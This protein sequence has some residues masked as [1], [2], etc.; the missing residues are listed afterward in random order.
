MKSHA[1]DSLLRCNEALYDL[2]LLQI[3]A[4]DH[5]VPASGEKHIMFRP[6]N[7]AV[8]RITKLK[9]RL[10]LLCKWVPL[11]HRAIIRTTDHQLIRRFPYFI[12]LVRMPKEGILQRP[13]GTPSHNQSIFIPCKKHLKF[14]TEARNV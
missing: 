1:S 10:T 3:N 9:N 4:P 14:E 8:N 12:N 5:F 13:I 6:M 7:R 11:P 2:I